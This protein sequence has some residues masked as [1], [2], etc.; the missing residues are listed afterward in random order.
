MTSVYVMQNDYGLTKIGISSNVHNRVASLKN[1]SGVGVEI[2]W[3]SEPMDRL[4]AR[5]VEKAAHERFSESRCYGEWFTGLDVEKVVGY[6][7][8]RMNIDTFKPR[9]DSVVDYTQCDIMEDD[10]L[11]HYCEAYIKKFPVFKM[12]DLS[13]SLLRDLK[14]AYGSKVLSTTLTSISCHRSENA[15]TLYNERSRWWFSA[16]IKSKEQASLVL[17]NIRNNH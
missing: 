7:V 4:L 13:D 8:L 15:I 3:Y 5:E 6:L 17:R 12:R 1:S 9:I 16:T 14:I 11:K 2:C 10:V